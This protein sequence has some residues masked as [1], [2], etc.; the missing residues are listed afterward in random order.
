MRSQ[1]I[2]H[3]LCDLA[4]I[5]SELLNFCRQI[6]GF[7]GVDDT[8]CAWLAGRAVTWLW[9]ANDDMAGFDGF[10]Q[11][12]CD[13]DTTRIFVGANVEEERIVKITK[14]GSISGLRTEC[15]PE[16]YALRFAL[17]DD[18]IIGF[19]ISDAIDDNSVSAAGNCCCDRFN[20]CRKSGS[21]R[22]DVGEI[23]SKVLGCVL[24]PLFR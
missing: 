7:Q 10:Q 21:A 8:S 13:G 4:R 22:K 1:V 11:F 20:L 23:D 18:V 5:E 16:S 12:L 17:L 2:G 24:S 9:I 15:A 3:R 6:R 19:V 14:L